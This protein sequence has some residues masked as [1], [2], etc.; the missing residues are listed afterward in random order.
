MAHIGEKFRLRPSGV[1]RV[2][3]GA[4]EQ[5]FEFDTLGHIACGDDES[6]T[7]VGFGIVDDCA[8]G[9]DKDWRAVFGIDVAAIGEALL[10]GIACNQSLLG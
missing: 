10:V 7:L 3:A 8:I 5:Q 9:L 1:F 6:F 2:P 4:S